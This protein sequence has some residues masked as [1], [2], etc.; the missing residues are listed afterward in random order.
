MPRNTSIESWERQPGESAKAYEAFSIYRD[1][2]MDRA[3]SKVSKQLG[4]S[5]ALMERWSVKYKWRE[6]CFKYDRDL[7][8]TAQKEARKEYSKMVTRHVR[9]GMK[10]QTAALSSLETLL[11]SKATLKPKDI[12]EF[13]ELGTELER[14]NRV[15]SAEEE[16]SDDDGFLEA[17]NGIAAEVNSVAGDVP[18]DIDP[19]EAQ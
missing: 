19:E 11:E 14:M 6:R 15:L 17:L 7:E 1:M 12:K 18:E 4:K 10:L 8:R 9:I 3:M 16:V 2:G 5:I 13:I